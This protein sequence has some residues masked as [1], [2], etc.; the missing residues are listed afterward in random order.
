MFKVAF[1]NKGGQPKY[2]ELKNFKNAET[3][4]PV[5][6]AAADF[7]KIS[8]AINT[9]ANQSSQTADLFF[10]NGKV[11]Q[12]PSGAQLVSFELKGGDSAQSNTYI[13]HQ[14]IIYP[15]TYKI[16]LNISLTQPGQLLTQGN[17]NLLCNTRLTSR[18]P[19][20]SLKSKIRRWDIWKMAALTI[21]P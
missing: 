16:D 18:R 7:N 21:I 15:D 11:E 17:L 8:Y 13:T 12:G 1:T 2:V 20:L 3:Q 9:S 19:I 4:Q 14:Y 6:L 5:R 10:S